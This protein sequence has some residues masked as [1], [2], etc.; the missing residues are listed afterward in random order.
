MGKKRE[1]EKGSKPRQQRNPFTTLLA[2]ASLRFF[3]IFMV[4]NSTYVLGV[5]HF[6]LVGPEPLS[7]AKGPQLVTAAKP[8]PPSHAF[9]TK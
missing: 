7:L 8:A 3:P 9:C 1:R 6:L 4:K 5:R 2:R